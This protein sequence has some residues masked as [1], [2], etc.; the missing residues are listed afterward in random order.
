MK[1]LKWTACGL[2]FAA[3]AMSSC[4]KQEEEVKDTTPAELKSFALLKADNA[5]LDKDY[6]PELISDNMI[7]RVKGGGS[8]KTFVATLTAG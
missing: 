3:L 2:L 7:I 4:Q 5:A 6:A 8:G 1:L